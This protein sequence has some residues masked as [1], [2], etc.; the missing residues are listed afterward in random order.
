M[1]HARY[2]LGAD[3][4]LDDK[5]LDWLKQCPSKTL[6]VFL[7]YSSGRLQGPGFYICVELYSNLI[8]PRFR[9]KRLI[10]V[11]SAVY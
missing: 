3:L 4:L 5:P 9:L 1:Y 7:R 2:S 6:I 8:I 11:R 10:K